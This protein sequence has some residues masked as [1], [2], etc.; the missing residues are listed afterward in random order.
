MPSDT[1]KGKAGEKLAKLFCRRI[2][3][4]PNPF[5]GLATESSVGATESRMPK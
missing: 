1:L 4:V 2:A 3:F 5:L